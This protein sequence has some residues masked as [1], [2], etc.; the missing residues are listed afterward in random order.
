[1]QF[2]HHVK[3]PLG[4]SFMK[5]GPSLVSPSTTFISAKPTPCVYFTLNAWMLQDKVM[6]VIESMMSSKWMHFG[7]RCQQRH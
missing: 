5:L 4:A 7:Q 6:E 1:M 2:S 3:P